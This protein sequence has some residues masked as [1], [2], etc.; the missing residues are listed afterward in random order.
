MVMTLRVISLST[1]PIVRKTFHCK[2][3]KKPCSLVN[4]NDF[5]LQLLS[6][7]SWRLL[8]SFSRSDIRGHDLQHGG[9]HLGDSHSRPSH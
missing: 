2:S 3:N 5:T 4:F 8:G 1:D 6:V 9:L 7:S